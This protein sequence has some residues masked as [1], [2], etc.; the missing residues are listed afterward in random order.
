[1]QS[2]FFQHKTENAEVVE[3]PVT[4]LFNRTPS[5]ITRKGCSLKSVKSPNVRKES[6]FSFSIRLHN[7]FSFLIVL[8]RKHGGRCAFKARVRSIQDV[9]KSAK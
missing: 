2:F 9:R 3:T 7:K 4:S 8:H 1:M 5:N 6:N